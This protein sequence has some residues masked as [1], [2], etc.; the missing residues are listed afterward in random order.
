ME[1]VKLPLLVVAIAVAVRLRRVRFHWLALVAAA[2][3][4]ALSGCEATVVE[5]PLTFATEN[6]RIEIPTL[7]KG[8]AIANV[9][10]PEAAGGS[11]SESLSYSLTPAVSGLT[12]DAAARVLSGTPTEAGTY[13]MT[14]TATDARSNTASLSFAITVVDGL[15]FGDL[16]LPEV[17]S[18]P[19]DSA[20][21]AVTLPQ[22]VGGTGVLTVPVDAIY[23]R[24]HVRNR[25][26]RRQR[27]ADDAGHLYH[28]LR[29]DGRCTRN[30]FPRIHGGYRRLRANDLG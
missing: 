5:K 4:V 3:V 19:Q 23:S 13:A 11:G 10:L 24:S 26:P 14:Y 27:D 21:P 20:I 17:M 6:P 22:A 1:R 28:D 15:S 2:T 9:T 25:Y 30:R 7:V 16:T 18:F 8:R 12:F 29:S